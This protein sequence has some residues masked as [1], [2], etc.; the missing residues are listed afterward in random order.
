MERPRLFFWFDSERDYDAIRSAIKGEPELPD[1][2]ED[3]LEAAQQRFAELTATGVSCKRVVVR[4]E[5]F[6]AWC[7]ES[8]FEQSIGSLGAYTITRVCKQMSEA[9]R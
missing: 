6:A 4:P 7:R 8:E 9:K 1:S 5:E 2:Y 3:W